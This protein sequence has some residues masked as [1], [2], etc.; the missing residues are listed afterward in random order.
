MSQELQV[1]VRDG[2]SRPTTSGVFVGVRPGSRGR[3][4]TARDYGDTGLYFGSRKVPRYLPS[5]LPTD[6]LESNDDS[7]P[8]RQPPPST[9]WGGERPVETRGAEDRSVPRLRGVTN[10]EY[11]PVP[12]RHGVPE[13]SPLCPTLRCVD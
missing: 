1:R 10:P 3:P 2:P 8:G 9:G 11:T 13:R 5:V 4:E 6:P 12:R 7:A